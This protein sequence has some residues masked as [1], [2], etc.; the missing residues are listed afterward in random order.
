MPKLDPESGGGREGIPWWSTQ[1]APSPSSTPLTGLS[2]LATG[3]QALMAWAREQ[4][5]APHADHLD[6]R[7]H[8]QCL[9]C[10]GQSVLAGVLGDA[11]DSPAE[12]VPDG[13]G[14]EEQVQWIELDPPRP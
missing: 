7:D 6:P 12:P 4:V 3:V 1:Q 2:G 14:T 11:A 9:A 5:L 10:R 8:P 13:D